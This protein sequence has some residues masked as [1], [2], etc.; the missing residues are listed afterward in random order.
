MRRAFTLIELLVVVGIIALLLAIM[1]P[2]LSRSKE[3]TRRTTCAA[4]LRGIGQA[5]TLYSAANDGVIVPG[6][7]P[8]SATSTNVW[9]VGNGK[10]FRP[11]WFALLGTASPVYAYNN[12]QPDPALTNSAQID[13]KLFL[14]P[15]VPEQRNNRN[16]V[17]GY[18]YQF[19]GNMRPKSADRAI[20]PPTR[21]ARANNSHTLIAADSNGTAVTVPESSRTPYRDDGN[22]MITARVNHGWALDPP[23]LTSTSDICDPGARSGPDARHRNSVNA[24]FGDTHV[25]SSTITDLGYGVAS[26]G[27]IPNSGMGAHNRLFSLTG[28]DDDPPAAN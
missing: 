4:N 6:R 5:W 3:G 25:D 9:D 28:G 20:L 14:C 22:D 23:R 26:D 27:T 24:L 15:S 19:L 12:P 18:N 1:V 2:T 16:H 11:R 21:I 17:Y 13:H 7:P 8:N 10:F